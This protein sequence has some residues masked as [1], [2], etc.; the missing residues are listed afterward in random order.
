MYKIE[1]QD[2]L[3]WAKNYNGPLLDAVLTDPPYEFGFMGKSWDCT[4]ITYN[5][6]MWKGILRL[7]KPGAH[8]LSFGGS[9]TYHRMACAIEDAGF[10]IRDQ[11]MWVF[12]S[13]FPKS[14]NIGKKNDKIKGNERNKIGNHI[15]P[16]GNKR[17]NNKIGCEYNTEMITGFK[18]DRTLTKG[19]SEFE[20]YGTALKPAHEPIVL[21]RKPLSEK[22]ITENV[23]KCGTGGLA[24]DNC[25][26]N[27][28]N[29]VPNVGGR[30]KHTRGDGY[31][32]KA[33]G[34]K[35]EANTQGR[36]PANFILTHHLG[37]EYIGK[38]KIKTPKHK[39]PSAGDSKFCHGDIQK[40]P[41]RRNYDLTDEDGKEAI[42]NWNCHPDC[43]VKRLNMQAGI[44]KSGTRKHNYNVGKT[45]KNGNLPNYGICGE[46][47]A[48][49]FNDVPSSEGNVSRFFFNADY[50]LDK[51]EEA[52]SVIYQA[53]ASRAER[54]AGLKGMEEKQ[55][56]HD[57][58]QKSIENAY[59]RNN[60]VAKNF[61]PTIK[62]IS[63]CKYLAILLL[64]PKEYVPRRILIP[65][66][67]SGSEIIG[68]ILAGWEEVIG[69]EKEKD[70]CEI[71]EARL[72]YWSQKK[73]EQGKLF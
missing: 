70:Y 21:A 41:D 24:I 31:G 40:R 60:S 15:G 29:E 25:R 45:G 11:I 14:L 8:L 57:G 56:S 38:Q 48:V 65:F 62:P 16:D 72:K 73:Q 22:T 42:D 7:L 46:R 63:L 27:Y 4:G 13:G 68:A 43:P 67:G 10:E 28:K 44:R 36:Y 58:R 5:V 49:P 17:Y 69:V 12:G 32:F 20:G 50:I 54:D 2:I 66:A 6:D 61:H 35:I 37:C 39:N 23:L 26:I 3:E 19:D 47:K 64:P 53:K 34:D 18:T 51:I 52:D 33:L 59:Q 1:N 30:G 9:R 55:Y 71:A